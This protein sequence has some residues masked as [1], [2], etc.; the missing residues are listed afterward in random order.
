MRSS[1]SA[2]SSLTRLPGEPEEDEVAV[3]A[4]RLGRGDR[5]ADDRDD[6]LPGLAGALGDQLFG[7][8]AEGGE[9]RR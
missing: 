6:A 3:V 7:P 2:S 1:A 8:V 5:L 4:I 9:S